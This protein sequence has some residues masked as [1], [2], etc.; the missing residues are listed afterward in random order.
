MKLSLPQKRH[1]PDTM[2]V[3][4]G[5]GGLAL[6][7]ALAW[8]LDPDRGGRRRA[9]LRDKA[10]H[11]TR[12]ISEAAE[13]SAR[14]IAQRGRGASASLRRGVSELRDRMQGRTVNDRVLVERVR[15][16]LGR[17]S[18]HPGAIDVI[19]H[20]GT[21]TITGPILASEVDRVLRGVSRVRG[22]VDIIER[23]EVHET[24][25]DVPALQGAG[26]TARSRREANWS[27][28]ART[29]IGATGTG[30]LA[31]GATR[32]DVL[33]TGAGLAGLAL[34]IRSAV[35]EPTVR[36]AG[37]GAGTRAVDI[38]KSIHVEAAVEEVFDFFSR[39]ENFPR[40]MSHVREVVRQDWNRWRWTVSGPAGIP[41]SWEA[42]V[43]DQIPN[44]L[45]AWQS[46]EGSSIRNSGRVRFLEEGTGTRIDIRMSYNPPGGRIGH[47][48]ASALGA[49]PKKQ[50]DDDMVRFK[51][52]LENEKATGREET[53]TK[54]EL[55]GDQPD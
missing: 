29:L 41:V 23:L 7:A 55:G 13:V 49:N 37:V 4:I 33:G 42:V 34:L 51:S 10:R 16:R 5:V 43:T 17:L 15:A 40:F 26:S 3:G 38:Q 1:H 36:I 14:D 24:S 48:L 47:A 8:L 53:V 45:I 20:E 9:M 12:S 18:S 54:E 30:L 2:M 52:L 35:N 32:R 50:M 31:W 6:G 39:L 11:A 21:I 19:G 44:E 27:P 25:G 22:V 46:V 28:A